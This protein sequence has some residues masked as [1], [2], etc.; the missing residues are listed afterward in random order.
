LGVDGTCLHI[1]RDSRHVDVVI[2][3]DHKTNHR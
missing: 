1:P 2:L 3:H